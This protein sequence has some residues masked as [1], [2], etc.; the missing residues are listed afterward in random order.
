MTTIIRLATEADAA[1]LLEIYA[2]FCLSTPVSFEMEPPSLDEM[3]LRIAAVLPSYPWLVCE[4]D[5]LI[6]GYAYA[7]KHRERAAYV[8][9]VDVSAYVRD[10]RRRG[11]LG[12]ALYTALFA[13]LRLQGYYNAVAGVTLP[14]PGSEGLHRSMG[15]QPVGVYPNIGYKCGGWHDVAWSQLALREPERVPRLPLPLD[16]VVGSRD[17]DEVLTVGAASLVAARPRSPDPSPA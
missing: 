17:W 10:G 5:G 11:G 4:E 8:W 7:S 12:R 1:Q 16:A 9:S 13:I 6:L 3:R 15:F 14:N 2:P